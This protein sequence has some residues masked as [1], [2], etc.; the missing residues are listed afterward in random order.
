MHMTE[1]AGVWE[2][3][4]RVHEILIIITATAILTIIIIMTI[5]I[6]II[7]IIIIRISIRIIRI[8]IRVVKVCDIQ[9]RS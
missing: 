1:V 5:I 2:E 4:K 8:S 3:R 7:R 6:R 9:N